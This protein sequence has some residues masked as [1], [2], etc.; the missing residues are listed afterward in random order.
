MKNVTKVTNLTKS[1][2]ETLTVDRIRLN[3]GNGDKKDY[4]CIIRPASGITEILD[5]EKNKLK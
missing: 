1:C 4:G 3:K 2:C 5:L